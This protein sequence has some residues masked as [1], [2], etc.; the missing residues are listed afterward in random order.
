MSNP[1]EPAP[2]TKKEAYAMGKVAEWWHDV[3]AQKGID[4]PPDEFRACLGAAFAFMIECMAQSRMPHA[5][6][7]VQ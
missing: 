5:P 4:P 6:T 3:C 7:R 1:T 2:M